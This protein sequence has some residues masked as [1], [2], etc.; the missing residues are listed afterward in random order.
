MK[1]RDLEKIMKTARLIN[2]KTKKGIDLILPKLVK[3][4]KKFKDWIFDSLMI[5]PIYLLVGA[6]TDPML[7]LALLTCHSALLLAARSEKEKVLKQESEEELSD[8]AE[9]EKSQ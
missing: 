4:E 9:N 5:L 1:K 7:G 6:F 8:S 3:N 2:E